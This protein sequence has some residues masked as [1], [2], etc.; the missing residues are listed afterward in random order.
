MALTNESTHGGLKSKLARSRRSERIATTSGTGVER[1]GRDV[2]LD[3]LLDLVGQRDLEQVTQPF[4]GVGLEALGK[5]HVG[6][7]EDEVFVLSRLPDAQ[8]HCV[9][10]TSPRLFP[11]DPLHAIRAVAHHGHCLVGVEVVESHCLVFVDAAACDSGKELGH[12]VPPKGNG[13]CRLAICR[14]ET[15]STLIQYHKNIIK[16]SVL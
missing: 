16:S 2:L 15:L 5:L 10:L 8:A 7:G 14:Q 4:N 12:D 6:E 13:L 9:G 3:Q 11:Q 1:P